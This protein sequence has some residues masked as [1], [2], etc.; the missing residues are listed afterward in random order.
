[1]SAYFERENIGTIIEYLSYK[2]SVTALINGLEYPASAVVDVHFGTDSIL[3]DQRYYRTDAKVIYQ[4]LNS[5]KSFYNLDSSEQRAVNG[6]IY[7]QYGPITGSPEYV[8]IQL[9][10]QKA[11]KHIEDTFAESNVLKDCYG[12]LQ[13]WQDRLKGLRPKGPSS[14]IFRL[15]KVKD[16]HEGKVIG[17][18]GPVIE[19]ITKVPRE[20]W[21]L[22]LSY[23]RHELY[24]DHR[25]LTGG[26]PQKDANTF[27]AEREDMDVDERISLFLRTLT[28]VSK[29]IFVFPSQVPL[30]VDGLPKGL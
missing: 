5:G 2:T 18:Q 24:V 16:R 21:Q 25:Y 9:I 30:L 20:L 22:S 13:Y 14:Q 19:G 12:E 10:D 4:V 11:I 26:I 17:L 15:T 8:S 6:F 29:G 1:M 3:R 23:Y 28:E 7:G 27:I